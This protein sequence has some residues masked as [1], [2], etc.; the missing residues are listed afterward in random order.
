MPSPDGDLVIA[1]FLI[2]PFHRVN[3]F[4]CDRHHQCRNL[5]CFPPSCLVLVHTN[6]S[7]DGFALHG[8]VQ[9]GRDAL[10]PP[11]AADSLSHNAVADKLPDVFD[12]E[13]HHATSDDDFLVKWQT[14]QAHRAGRG[15]LPRAPLSYCFQLFREFRYCGFY[16]F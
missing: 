8:S 10:P 7:M 5:H 6:Y 12:R 15:I 9:K 14:H 11:L 2:K 16:L 1:D 4:G 13:N 3:D